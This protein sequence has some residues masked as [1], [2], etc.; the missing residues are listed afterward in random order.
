M[1]KAAARLGL[2]LDDNAGPT[3]DIACLVE[4]CEAN[5]NQIGVRLTKDEAVFIKFRQIE[6][7]RSRC[8]R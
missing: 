5:D 6:L 4:L 3:P 7:V 8:A 2:K 1:R